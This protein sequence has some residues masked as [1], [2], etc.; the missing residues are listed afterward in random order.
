MTE[1]INTDVKQMAQEIIV[2]AMLHTQAALNSAL[3]I[4]EIT[5]DDLAFE[6]SD[7]IAQAQRHLM[8][9]AHFMGKVPSRGK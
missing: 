6:A 5:V 9:A 2:E 8:R 3:A 4:L 1:K 7:S